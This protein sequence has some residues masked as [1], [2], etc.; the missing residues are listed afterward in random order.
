MVRWLNRGMIGFLLLGTPVVCGAEDST[1]TGKYFQVICHFTNDQVATEALKTAE[2]VWPVATN[3]FV[4][5]DQKPAKPLKIHL[6]RT[7][8][9]YEKADAEL[10]GGEFRK[11]LA[12]SHWETQAAYILLQPDCSDD[13]LTRVGLPVPTRRLI[14]H[15][16]AHLFRYATIPNHRSHPR[17]LA[18]GMAT[19]VEQRVMAKGHWSPGVEDDPDTATMIVRAVDLLEKGK[20]PS[21]ADILRDRIDAVPWRTRYGLRWLLFRF[22][23]DSVEREAFNS[24]MGAVRRLGGGTDYGNRLVASIEERLGPD[25]MNAIDAEFRASLGALKPRWEEVYR[26]L[27]TAGDGWTQIAFP[28]TNA[29]AWRTAP[30]ASDAYALEGRFKIH[31]GRKQQLNLLLGRESSGFVSVAFVAGY[32]VTI[33][34]YQAKENR[35]ER[36]GSAASDALQ[37]DRW[38]RFSAKI[39]ADQLRVSLD[40]KPALAVP[41]AGRSMR[42]PWGLGAQNG[43]VGVWRSVGLRPTTGR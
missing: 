22:L 34:R 41:L 38:V 5:A 15:E 42:G 14:A 2:L 37:L 36:L 17:W 6:F 40:E 28:D 11:N 27:E 7:V 26:S 25:R 39:G 19:C 20:L 8:E 32:G 3:L 33:F 12:F 35:W 29:I 9:Q 4:V 18:D 21:V 24:I 1:R 43:S 13:T 10:T 31:R 30:A 16:A 23:H